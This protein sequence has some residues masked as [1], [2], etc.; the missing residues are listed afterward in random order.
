MTCGVTENW[1]HHSISRAQS[2]P[3][4]DGFTTMTWGSTEKKPIKKR[5]GRFELAWVLRNDVELKSTALFVKFPLKSHWNTIKIMLISIPL[6]PYFMKLNSIPFF[7]DVECTEMA[8]FEWENE[9]VSAGPF[10]HGL[11]EVIS[12]VGY[13][14]HAVTQLPRC[15][16]T[17]L[18]M[19]KEM[20]GRLQWH[21]QPF[22]CWQAVVCVFAAWRKLRCA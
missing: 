2:P 21:F 9:L 1:K 11:C 8:F 22:S 20:A 10:C 4:G 6:N 18:K 15:N 17:T 19:P 5:G 3:T 13:T 12:R 14:R 16:G 7:S